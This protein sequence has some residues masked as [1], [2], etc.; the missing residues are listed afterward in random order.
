[1]RDTNRST[2]GRIRAN[3]RETGCQPAIRRIARKNAPPSS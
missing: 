3:S 2:G 1:M